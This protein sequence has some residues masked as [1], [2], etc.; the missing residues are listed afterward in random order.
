VGICRVAAR[1]VVRAGPPARRLRGRED[2]LP[3]P[4]GV[5]RSL[6]TFPF[7]RASPRRGTAPACAPTLDLACARRGLAARFGRGF[8]RRPSLL[9]RTLEATTSTRRG[10]DVVKTRGP[11]PSEPDAANPAAL[12]VWTR[13]PGCHANSAGCDPPA[14]SSAEPRLDAAARHV[15]PDEQRQRDDGQNDKNRDQ[16]VQPPRNRIGT[17]DIPRKILSYAGARR[18][19]AP[20]RRVSAHRAGGIA[21]R[22]SRSIS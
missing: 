13:R 20:S 8:T 19:L 2:D 22:R 10:V 9:R 7:R 18:R 3:K 16:H 21:S 12:L 6:G 11:S 17:K 4:L 14:V 1:P 15:A 5:R